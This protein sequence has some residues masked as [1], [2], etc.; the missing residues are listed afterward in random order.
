MIPSSKKT[1]SVWNDF[2]DQLRAFITKRIS[3]PDVVEDILQ[4]TFLKIHRNIDTLKDDGRIRSW[5]YQIARNTI[6]DYYRKSKPEPC[7][8]EPDSLPWEENEESASEELASGLREMVEALP[9]P[10]AHALLN[11]EF[12]GMTQKE[13]AHC[14]NISLSG[15]KSRVQ[16]ARQMLRDDLMRCCHYEFDQLGAVIDYHPITCCCCHQYKEE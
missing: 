7:N 9:E 1:E 16:R 3:D 15:A 10:Y 4:D 2:S 11:T 8:V 14:L 6:I 13:L 5:I 12:E